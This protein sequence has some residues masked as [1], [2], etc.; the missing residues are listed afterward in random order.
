MKRK[1]LFGI[2]L[3][4]CAMLA[5][6]AQTRVDWHLL[7]PA[8]DS[9]Y[10]AGILEAYCELGD[11]APRRKVVVA[12][13]DA[14]FD[15]QHEAL[16]N[17]LWR[18]GKEIAGN[19]K[20][21]DKNGY[22]DDL[23]GWNFLASPDGKLIERTSDEAFR[24]FLK[25]KDR[26]DELHGKKR[27]EEENNEYIDYLKWAKNSPLVSLYVGASFNY[28]L[29]KSVEELDRLL[30]EK[31]PDR[32]PTQED[33]AALNP[34]VQQSG[35]TLQKIAYYTYSIVWSFGNKNKKWDDLYRNR[36]RSCE[37]QRQ[38]CE[39]A[40]AALVDE[41][42]LVNDDLNS[43]SDRY[44]G[45]HDF[46]SAAADEGTAVAGIIAAASGITRG[47]KGISDQVELMLLRALPSSGDA[48]DKDIALAIR[49]AVDQGADIINMS[50][51]KYVLD[52]REWIDDA[53]A[54]AEKHDVLIVHAA[55]DNYR[56]TGKDPY[57]PV[58]QGL[59]R[60][61]AF[62][63]IITVGASDMEG[64]PYINSNHGTGSV[65]LFAP[66]VQLYTTVC[67]DNYRKVTGTRIAAPVVAGIAAMLKSYYPS[68]EASRIRDILVRTARQTPS[69]TV[70]FPRD[71]TNSGGAP[72]GGYDQLCVSGGIIDAAA[73]V[74]LAHEICEGK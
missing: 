12:V 51:G 74:K 11:N 26:F 63:N 14:G 19:A 69:A 17:V 36:Y 3:F 64:N 57:F 40:W 46:L 4:T 52:N 32:E 20:D 24:Q 42:S 45:N 39:K 2:V 21:D 9:V 62:T 44:Y 7:S 25:V 47:I 58:K 13:I 72:T 38:E 70:P 67:G 48:Y 22:P 33:F 16:A 10:G 8:R 71:P 59:G 23:H 53:I 18:N 50:F 56:D 5:A 41:R 35:D 30:R 54:Y 43:L 1:K 66:G 37:A 65:D 27:S 6:E 68:L 15:V 29:A 28:N 49:Y 55:G 73:A 34:I 61:R 60:E 31:C